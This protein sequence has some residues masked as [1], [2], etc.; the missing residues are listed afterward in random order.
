MGADIY[1]ESRYEKNQKKTRPLFDAAVATRD[2]YMRSPAYLAK[3]GSEY[4][5]DEADPEFKRLQA[6]VE[7]QYNAMYGVGY[8]R[9]PYNASAMLWVI[10][11]S[12]W[13]DVSGK[14][15]DKEG[16]MSVQRMRTFKK[17]LEER[18]ITREIAETYMRAKNTK[19]DDNKY[20]AGFDMNKVDGWTARWQK[21]RQDLIGLLDEAIK[22]KEPLRCSL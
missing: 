13:R 16:Y 14:L 5:H 2:A 7:K 9:D 21:D 8:Y 22:L 18:P 15:T 10:G 1:L 6:E 17:M 11:L 4:V 19:T 3:H 20:P 12:W